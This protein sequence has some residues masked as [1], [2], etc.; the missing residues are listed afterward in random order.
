NVVAPAIEELVNKTNETMNSLTPSV[1]LG[2]EV[3]VYNPPKP[4]L[5]S[6]LEDAVRK[7]QELPFDVPTLNIN[8]PTIGAKEIIELMGSGSGNLD[9][10]VSEWAAEKGDSFFIALWANVFQFTPA[11][12]RGVK[13]I[14]FRDYIYN[15]DDAIDN[16]LAIYLLSRR[17]ADK[18]LP[19]T[20][21]SLFVY[22]KSIIEF[23]NQSAAR[24]CLAFDE[25]NKIDKIQQLVRSSTKR[26]VTVNGP[27]YRKWIEAGGE[28]EILFGN[29]IE[30]P[31][32][33]T[34]QDINTK[35][36]ALKASWNRYATLTATVER[37][38]RFVRI[39]EVLFNQFSTSMR[40]ITE[41]EEATLANREL[42]IKLFMEQLERVREDEL[43]DIWTVCLKLVCRSRFFRTES[44]RILLG[45]ER[46]K[47]ENPAID[48]REAA[49]V[50]V[51]E[52]IAF[53]VS[54]QMKIQVA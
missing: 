10:Y 16:A 47:K 17:L 35:A 54:T 28:N 26:T 50:S 4:L 23:R 34:V 53:W 43:T 18:P 45:I 40:E 48:V 27:V 29:L 36:A 22:N 44:E 2:M 52:Y 13:I 15:S 7:F 30:L 24:L 14:T 37:N 19:G 46:V 31:S 51:I 6:G 39:K 5:S 21:M 12:L 11:D 3:I 41:G 49:T 25:L 9:T 38:K 32:A 42:I 33:I 1:L 20:E 8:L